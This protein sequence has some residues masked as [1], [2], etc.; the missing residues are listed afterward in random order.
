MLN[1]AQKYNDTRTGEKYNESTNNAACSSLLECCSNLLFGQ[2]SPYRMSYNY[3][4]IDPGWG[5]RVVQNVHNLDSVYMHSEIYTVLYFKT[6]Y[7]HACM[8]ISLDFFYTQWKKFIPTP[9]AWIF[10]V[11]S[12]VYKEKCKYKKICSAHSESFLWGCS[13][14]CCNPLPLDPLSSQEASQ[15]S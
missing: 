13:R 1:N 6:H 4:E 2:E 9:W 7:L 3:T 14:L 5:P 8:W 12:P 10:N 11:G 15:L